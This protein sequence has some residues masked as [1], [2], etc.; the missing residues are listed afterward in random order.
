MQFNL[1]RDLEQVVQYVWHGV[2][3]ICRALALGFI[4]ILGVCLQHLYRGCVLSPYGAF[5]RRLW[6]VLAV[7]RSLACPHGFAWLSIRC[8]GARVLPSTSPPQ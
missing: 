8:G 6:V 5:P 3:L 7:S 2:A 1:V 4:S